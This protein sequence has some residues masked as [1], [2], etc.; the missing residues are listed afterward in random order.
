MGNDAD[1]KVLSQLHSKAHEAKAAQADTIFQLKNNDVPDYKAVVNLVAE[2]LKDSFKLEIGLIG[3][4]FYETLQY[5]REYVPETQ[6]EQ[7]IAKL[8]ENAKTDYRAFRS[9]ELF[10]YL[11]AEYGKHFPSLVEWKKE[12]ILGTYKPP[13]RPTGSSEFKNLHRDTLIVGQIKLLVSIGYLATRNKGKTGHS[14]CDVVV[15][16]LAS[17]KQNLSYSTIEGIWLRREKL[18]S[19]DILIEALFQSTQAPP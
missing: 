17:I 3:F 10:D 5:Y 16:A 19:P 18:R 11:I 9:L 7:E 6:S 14:A 4:S 13:N 15:D 8:V 12:R 2:R 1:R